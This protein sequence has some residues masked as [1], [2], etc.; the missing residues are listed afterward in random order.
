VTVTR[1]FRRDTTGQIAGYLPF[2]SDSRQEG[3]ASH[4]IVPPGCCTREDLA[5]LTCSP[6]WIH[7][8]AWFFVSA[9]G[10]EMRCF[11][12]TENSM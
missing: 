5:A 9:W 11:S 3:K 10:S 4:E 6:A 12:S 7:F 8:C 1:V 2:R